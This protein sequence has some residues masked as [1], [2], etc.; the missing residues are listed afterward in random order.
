MP[1]TSVSRIVAAP[2]EEVWA[3]LADIANAGRWNTAWPRIEITSSQSQ[4]AGT[5][6]RAHT[7]DGHAFDFQ[8]T[9]WAPPEYIAFAP[10]HG[11]DTER[12]ILTLESH[13]FLLRPAGDD[14]THVELI[15]SAS[16]HG[17]RGRL[18]GLFLWSGH[19]KHG[20]NTALDGLQAL[21]EPPERDDSEPEAETSSASD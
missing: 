18:I 4:G 10:V 3:A 8:I 21:F 9:D 7:A 12:Y 5:T 17:I 6:F 14:R 19:Q 16:A 15:A 20:L 13:A 2:Q 11:E 1:T